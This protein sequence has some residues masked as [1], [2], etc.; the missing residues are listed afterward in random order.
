MRLITLFNNRYNSG[1]YT[2]GLG[3]GGFGRFNLFYVGYNRS[4]HDSACWVYIRMVGID[5]RI[6]K[7]SASVCWCGGREYCIRF[8]K[9]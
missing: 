5:F 7:L 1:H 2:G 8:G 4:S 3:V 9:T 6:S